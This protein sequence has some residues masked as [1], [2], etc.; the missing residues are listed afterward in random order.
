MNR[1]EKDCTFWSQE[2]FKQLCDGRTEE[3]GNVM[4]ITSTQMDGDVVLGNR[5]GK[6]WFIYDLDLHVD[7]EGKSAEIVKV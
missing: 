6:I 1:T 5:K 2:F 4:K 3:D 7:W